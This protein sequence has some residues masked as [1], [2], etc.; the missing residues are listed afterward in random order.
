MSKC[1]ELCEVGGIQFR[2]GMGVWIPIWSLHH[3]EKYWDN[4]EEFRPERFMPGNKESIDPFTYMP[5]GQGPRN[6][7]GMRFALL[8]IKLVLARL[9]KEFRIERAPELHIP[10]KLAVKQLYSPEEP[11]YVKIVSRK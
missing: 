11:V 4:A 6:C 10:L 2:K 1:T 9:L 5:F 8:E 7:V 3:D